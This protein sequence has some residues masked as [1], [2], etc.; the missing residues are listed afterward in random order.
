[1]S[2][3][4]TSRDCRARIRGWHARRL[5]VV[6][7]RSRQRVLSLRTVLRSNR[8][9]AIGRTYAGSPRPRRR[10][11]L[12]AQVLSQL[13]QKAQKR[14]KNLLILFVFFVATK[15]LVGNGLDLRH[16]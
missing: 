11:M 6:R 4:A 3:L 10:L 1:P 9:A 5:R 13:P 2:H 7:S 15:Y 8:N 12:A 16:P 14:T